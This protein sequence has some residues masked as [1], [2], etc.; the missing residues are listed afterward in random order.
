MDGAQHVAPKS[1]NST[2]DMAQSTGQ[3]EKL[4]LLRIKEFQ[5]QVRPFHWVEFRNVSL[6]PDLRTPL[7]VVDSTARR[8][9]VSIKD[10]EAR[11]AAAGEISRQS[12]KDTALAGLA[13]DAA[14]SGVSDI[15]QRAIEAMMNMSSRDEAACDSARELGSLGM[16]EQASK[17]IEAVG[18]MSKRD[19]ALAAL[20]K[21][22]ASAGNSSGVEAAL[23]GM[24]NMSIRDSA[25]YEAAMLLSR[26]GMR[27]EAMRVVQNISNLSQR[28][29][30]YAELAK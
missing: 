28:D 12:Q 10:F 3:F 26:R 9:P 21:Q 16:I 13:H 25:A 11:L 27:A 18:N 14:V 5:F 19:T 30:A 7:E 6:E 29:K 22:G 4:P 17:A 1:I 24:T 23:Q 2:G 8:P 15:A 20:A